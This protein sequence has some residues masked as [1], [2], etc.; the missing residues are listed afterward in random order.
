MTPPE[1][2]SVSVIVN[3]YNWPEALKL[4]LQSLAGQSERRFEIIVA[5]DG[6]RPDTADVVKAFAGASSI[7]VKHVWHED[8][9]FRRAAI[10]NKAITEACASYLIFIDGDCILQP[11]FVARHRALARPNYLVT[12]SRVLLGQEFSQQLLAAGTW[13]HQAFRRNILRHR[14]KGDISKI[15]A[16]F[17]RLP[18]RPMSD[19]RSSSSG[20]SRAAISRAGKAMRFPSAASTRPSRAGAT[21]MPTSSSDC[22]TRV[23]SGAPAPG[24][25]RYCISGTSRPIRAVPRRTRRSCSIG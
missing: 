10:L 19:Y 9:G 7:P 4:S 22:R 2:I 6:S 13:S 20:A 8:V 17:V 24:P 11:D 16:F 14:L 18:W 12:G 15:V 3:T 25:Q 21:R 23:S 5:D 1:A